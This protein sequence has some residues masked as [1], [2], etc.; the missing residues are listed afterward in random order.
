MLQQIEGKIVDWDTARQRVANW[1]Q[2]G[3]KVVFTNGC[4]DILHYGHVRLLAQ[5]RALGHRLIVAVNAS[6]S[7][8]RLKGPDR[9]INDEKNRS[10]LLAALQAVDLVVVFEQDTPL[11]LI[12]WLM[13]DHLVKGGDYQIEQIVGAKEVQEN[14][15]QVHSLPFAEGYSTTSIIERIQKLDRK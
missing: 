6:S 4:F 5:A 13:P 10:L 14:G 7:V 12:R 2:A 3:E 11:E 1:Q 15:G 8:R 9:P